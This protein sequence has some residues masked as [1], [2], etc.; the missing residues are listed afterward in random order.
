MVEWAFRTSKTIELE[1]RPI[2]VR[3]ATRTRGH[4][5]VVMLAYRI[6]KEL[7]ERWRHLNVTVQEGLNEL[8][9]LCTVEVEEKGGVGYNE[10]PEPRQSIKKLLEAAGVGLPEVVRSTGVTV[11]KKKEIAFKKKIILIIAKLC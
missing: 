10:M 3:L 8:A 4:V 2:H 7:A 1:L 11:T 9:S 5:L 6:V